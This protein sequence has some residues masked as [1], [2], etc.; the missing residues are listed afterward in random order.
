MNVNAYY[1]ALISQALTTSAQF[2]LLSLRTS[3]KFVI[4]LGG[5]FCKS[6]NFSDFC[7]KF[8]MFLIDFG[9]EYIYRNLTEI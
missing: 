8:D 9:D 2:A 3:A 1:A 5:F 6:C 7:N 4:M